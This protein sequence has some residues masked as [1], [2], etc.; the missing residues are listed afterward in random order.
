[1]TEKQEQIFE[2]CN[3]DCLLEKIEKY[4]D[5]NRNLIITAVIILFIAGLIVLFIEKK[6]IG[7]ITADYADYYPQS[8]T[9]YIDI[10]LDDK[11]IQEINNFTVLNIKDLPDLFIRIFNADYRVTKRRKIDKLINQ[12]L[13]DEFSYGFWNSKGIDRSLIIFPIKRE[14][15]INP[16]FRLLLGKNE[17]LTDKTYQGF[18]IVT[19]KNKK[20]AYLI[21][22]ERLFVADSYETLTSIINNYILQ[23]KKSLYDKKD[24]RR[25]L[26][27]V[28]KS[29]I[30]T[31]LITNSPSDNEVL[32][33][34]TNNKFSVISGFLNGL[35]STTAISVMIDKDIFY[36]NTYTP[37]D[38]LII[39]E[40]NVEKAFRT[41]FDSNKQ[42]LSSDFLPQNTISYFTVSG[43]KNYMNLYL[44]L[45]GIK[46]KPEFE[47][48]KQFVKMTTEL[49]YDKDIMETFSKNTVFATIDSGNSKPGYAVI[50]SSTPKTDLV[51][52]KFIKLLQIQVPSAE[53]SKLSY[54]NLELNTVVSSKLPVTLCY[55]NIGKNLYAIGDK[56]AVE[57]IIDTIKNKKCFSNNNLF[58]DFKKHSIYNPGITAFMDIQKINAFA[59]QNRK[60]LEGNYLDKIKNNINAAFITA[61]YKDN[62]FIGSIQFSLKNK[63]LNKK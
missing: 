27:Y 25:A 29:R 42:A 28:D 60:S 36:F 57:S 35:I 13:G 8:T 23:D 3:N 39:G 6:E 63:S 32:N 45:I 7:G 49:D 54:K 55:G 5:P 31:I 51:I 40:E 34:I 14:S 22:R 33:N 44:E 15:K 37:Y 47:Q 48:L 19:A 56:L 46:A 53:I 11:S 20:I 41:V 52:S 58:S 2:N 50:L 61:D 24:V 1:M 38:E 30:G 62:A 4:G 12:V 17:K 10:K 16:L 26:A 9:A 59:P 43:L 21:N 18:R